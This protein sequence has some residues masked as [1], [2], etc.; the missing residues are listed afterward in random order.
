M[1]KLGILGGGQLGK[2]LC[3]A[4]A[5]LDIPVSVLDENNNFPAAKL[6]DTF[7]EGNFKEYEDVYKFGQNVDVLT[8][9]IEHV[10]T[11][12]LLKLEEEGK[13]I[14]P[15]PD[16]L[17][18]IKDKGLQKLL[19]INHH[20]PTS[21]FALFDDIQSIKDGLATN[22]I[23]YPFVQKIRT[24][25]YDGKGVVV[26]KNPN[27]LQYL[28]EGASIVEEMVEIEKELAVIVCRNAQGEVIAYPAVEMEFHPTANLVE[29]LSS[30]ATISPL[31][32]A[33]AEELA[34][35]TIEAFDICGL[36]AVEMFL[37]KDN[38]LLINEVAPRPHNS[39]HHTIDSF[40][41]SQFQQHLRGVLNL[42]L[43]AT[44][45]KSPSVMINL[46]GEEGFSGEV[47]YE[48]LAESLAIEGVNVHLYGKKTT[49]PFRK[50]GHVTIIADDLATAKK[51]A[52][53]V[54][55]LLKV[56]AKP[57]SA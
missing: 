54:Q 34:I 25:G 51:R 31:I 27:D 53:K 46:L 55:Q 44:T 3:I 11:D 6:C 48:G 17:N 57:I 16:K 23:R 37:T 35:K 56:K 26:I 18:I 4:A 12:A 1:Q 9:E 8:I 33:E 13:I 39:G 50:M 43:G 21:N 7:V 2:M 28:L 14:H 41:T 15:A 20:L 47:I 40:Y 24:G 5:P 29:Y 38:H 19:Y 45:M 32:E 42:P 52:K 30:P 22:A 36:L 10:N 49:K